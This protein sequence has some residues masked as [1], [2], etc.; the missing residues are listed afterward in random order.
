MLYDMKNVL[1]VAVSY[2]LSIAKMTGVPVSM[3]FGP[4]DIKAM[5]GDSVGDVLSRI[6]EDPTPEPVR[7][8]E[9]RP[10]HLSEQFSGTQKH[11]FGPPDPGYQGETK[12]IEGFEQ[13]D[14]GGE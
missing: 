6:G 3:S 5:P 14:R 2:T 7:P 4:H 9:D 10:I 8:V 12:L 13:P 1:R 11:W